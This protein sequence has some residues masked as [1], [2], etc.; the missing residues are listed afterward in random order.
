[1]QSEHTQ[2]RASAGKWR[3]RLRLG[4]LPPAAH[5]VES[6]SSGRVQQRC[7]AVVAK[8]GS[9][10]RSESLEETGGGCDGAGAEVQHA[11]WVSNLQMS[12]AVLLFLLFIFLYFCRVSWRRMRRRCNRYIVRERNTQSRSIFGNTSLVHQ[13][14]CDALH[15]ARGGCGGAGG[16]ARDA[17]TSRR[18]SR[19]CTHSGATVLYTSTYC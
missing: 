13:Q 5:L 8:P 7:C 15:R 6:A 10:D 18:S 1:M 9:R 14:P 3:Q 19:P 17:Q 11:Y 12:Q 16:N 2:L 4:R